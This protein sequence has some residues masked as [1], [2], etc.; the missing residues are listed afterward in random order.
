MIRTAVL[1][2]LLLSAGCGGFKSAAADAG[3]DAGSAADA[4]TP[5]DAPIAAEG[6]AEGGSGP[7]TIVQQVADAGSLNAIWGS[8]PTD[9][10]TV[11]DNGMMYDY[12]GTSWNAVVGMTGAKM[13]GVWG[14]GPND[15]YAV[16]ILAA[17]ARGVI[18]HYGGMGWIEQMETNWG[19]NDVW[20]IAGG[21]IYAVGLGGHIFTNQ[22][23]AGWVDAGHLP[24]NQCVSGQTSDEPILWSLWGNS[25]TFV[26]VAADVDTFFRYDGMTSWLY[27]C[28]PV[29]RSRTYRSVW[30]PNA[31][32]APNMFLGANYYGVWLDNGSPTLLTLNEEKDSAEKAN[33]YVWGIWGTAS[34]SVAFV[35]NKGRIMSWDGGPN[36]LKI[37]PSPVQL[38]LYGVWGTS[39]NDVWIVGDQATIM[40]GAIPH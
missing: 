33:E 4:A 16:G 10:H 14:T 6:G 29:D 2:L 38:D 21:T 17:N 19:L 3:G 12:D 11:G 18:F 23:G 27:S 22:N 31:P 32:G 25:A 37:V 9:I 8:G 1:L 39:L 28:D 26:D 5:P 35:G 13:Q 36:G 34:D 7:F 15:I 24:A 20:G 40:H 30:G